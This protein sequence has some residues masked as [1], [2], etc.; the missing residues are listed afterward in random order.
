VGAKLAH[1]GYLNSILIKDGAM[2]V[3]KVEKASQS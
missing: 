3:N 1:I 2:R